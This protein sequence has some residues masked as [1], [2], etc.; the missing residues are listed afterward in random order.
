MSICFCFNN[1]GY[2]G[3]TAHLQQVHQNLDRSQK[4]LPCHKWHQYYSFTTTTFSFC[5]NAL[6]CRILLQD[7][8][9]GITE[10]GFLQ[11]RSPSCHKTN[12]VKALK[13]TCPK[14]YNSKTFHQNQSTTFSVM[15]LTERQTNRLCRWKQQQTQ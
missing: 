14:R 13:G 6:F 15:L 2:T 4:C 3:Y 11:A 9:L 7:R 5:L 1:L 10:A 8:A 12:S